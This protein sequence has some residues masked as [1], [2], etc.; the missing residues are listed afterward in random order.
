MNNEQILKR[1]TE[2]KLI[3]SDA[4]KFIERCNSEIKFI[5]E[6]CPHSSIK[7]WTNNDGDGQFTVQYCNICGLQKD[8]ILK[9]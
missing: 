2:L 6:I 7:Q 9:H 3:V 4:K 1:T 8:G 5:Q